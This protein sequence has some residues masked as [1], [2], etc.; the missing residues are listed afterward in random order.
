M[1]VVGR[2]SR[3]EEAE[4]TNGIF[5]VINAYSNLNSKRFGTRSLGGSTLRSEIE[6]ARIHDAGQIVHAALEA[7]RNACVP[8]ASTID[9]DEAAT[10]VIADM[11]AEPLFLDHAGP[12]GDFPAATCISV[13]DEV[14]H[15][16]PGTRELL[17]GEIVS[18][19]CGVRLKDWCADAA[20]TVPVGAIDADRQDLLDVTESILALAIRMIRPGRRWSEIARELQAMTF[21]A[22]YGIVEQF[23]GHGIGRQLHELPAVPCVLTK[24]LLGRGDFTLHSG[25]VLA[26][27]PIL[28]MDAPAIRADNT[29]AGVPTFVG[30]DGWTVHTLMGEITSHFEHTVAV[31]PQ[32][33]EILTGSPPIPCVE[34]RSARIPNDELNTGSL[35]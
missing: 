12:H 16:I 3:D 10:K 29:A 30:D 1:V 27:E 32:G 33:A 11:G 2:A 4:A 24:S 31:R 15:G 9:L 8:G 34:R 26:I 14:V 18:I 20:I 7:A 5:I 25:M 17:A 23:C 19:D 21:D 28:A 22:G 13:E 6:I 35:A